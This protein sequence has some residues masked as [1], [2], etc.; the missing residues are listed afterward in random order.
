MSIINTEDKQADANYTAQTVTAPSPLIQALPVPAQGTSGSQRIGDSILINKIDMDLTFSYSGTAATATNA[1]QTFRYWLVRYLKTPA[2]SGTSNFNLSEFLNVDASSQYTTASL[3][4]TDTNENFQVMLCGDV[5]LRLPTL[6]SA[7]IS[8]SK[9]IP[10]RHSCHFHQIFNGSTSGNITD[11]MCFL[12]V[13][14]MN[15]AN[16]GGSS[17]VINTTRMWYVDN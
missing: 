12:V 1:D 10:I 4:N 13:V 14:A 7:Q 17:T 8:V 11:N 5:Q 6:A 3:M 15:P 9:T 2:T 16:T